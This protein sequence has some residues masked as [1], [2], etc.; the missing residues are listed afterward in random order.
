MNRRISRVA[1]IA[2][3]VFS[4][5]LVC[6]GTGLATEVTSTPFQRAIA[7]WMGMVALVA[8]D[9][10]EAERHDEK[11]DEDEDDD[12]DKDARHGRRRS[13]ERAEWDGRGRRGMSGDW[14][15]GG[16]GPSAHGPGARGP[17]ARGPGG[18]PPQMRMEPMQHMR[19]D[20]LGR[21]SEIIDRL[22]RI[23][24]KL[25]AAPRMGNPWSPRPAEA[26]R[27][28]R[29]RPPVAA[30]PPEAQE[31]MRTMMEEGRKRMAE[32]HERMEQAR[33]KFQEMEERIKKLEAE[34]ERLKAGR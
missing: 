33:K 18:P 20:A 6:M 11:D 32:A 21:V 22:T 23:E 25:D 19:V 13:G 1:L 8:D 16:R 10:T 29:A 26:G 12:E 4:L 14:G 3:V 15:P 9:G 7:S 30:M 17:G 28:E 2:C 5:V 34:V 27:G 31:R 24:Q